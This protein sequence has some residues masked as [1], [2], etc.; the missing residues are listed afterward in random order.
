MYAK[1]NIHKIKQNVCNYKRENSVGL[2]NIYKFAK[3]TNNLFCFS[4]ELIFF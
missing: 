1:K 3:F 2:Q 4:I